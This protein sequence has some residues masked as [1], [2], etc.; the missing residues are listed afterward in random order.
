MSKTKKNEPQFKGYMSIKDVW[1]FFKNNSLNVVVNRDG[2]VFLKN[3]S[4]ENFLPDC[5]YE[6]IDGR[7][8]LGHFC[9]NYWETEVL[10]S[11]CSAMGRSVSC[12]C[13]TSRQ[14]EIILTKIQNCLLKEID[15]VKKYYQ[16]EQTRIVNS[17]KKIKSFDTK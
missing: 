11:F 15:K 14:K 7:I 9:Y 16:K 4:M 3:S 17:I 8:C 12:E 2:Y 5:F 6:D 13:D 1:E 10:N